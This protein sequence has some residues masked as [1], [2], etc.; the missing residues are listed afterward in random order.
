MTRMLPVQGGLPEPADSLEQQPQEE[1]NLVK[2]E[3][4]LTQMSM[5]ALQ[6]ATCPKGIRKERQYEKCMLNSEQ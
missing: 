4:K 2:L 1:V 3:W 5:R 6:K